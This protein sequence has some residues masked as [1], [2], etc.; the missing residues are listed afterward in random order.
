ML[1]KIPEKLR[2][3][4]E[5]ADFPLYVAGGAVRDALSGFD[6]EDIDLAAPAAA[7]EMCTL[8]ERCGFTVCGVYKNTG[9]VNLS[10]GQKKYEFTSFRTDV[11]RRG[12]NAGG[13]APAEVRFTGSIEEDAKRRDFKCNAVYYDIA[14]DRIADPL[15]GVADIRARTVN[16]T[17]DADEVFAEDGLRLMRLARQC[18]QTGF[19]PSLE[20][21]FGAKFNAARIQKI[22]PERIFAE[23]KLLL[24]ADEKHGVRF[25]H[26]DGLKLLEGT[27]VLGYILPELAAGKGMPQR[28]DFHDHDVLEHSLRAAKYA[29]PRVRLAALLHDAGKPWCYQNT[30]KYHGHDEAGA[31]IGR[32]ILERLKAPKKETETVVRL[33]GAHMYD[34]DGKARES[35]VR[36]FIAKNADIYELLLLVKQADY[37][38]CKD[39]TDVCPT[40]VK[41]EDIRK[42]M[43]D[44]GAPFT[45]KELKIDGNALKGLFP[46]EKIGKALN[47]LFFECV[48]DG[49]KN[50]P[51]KLRTAAEK[52][53]AKEI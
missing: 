43:L 16:T 23:L 39:K 37:M 50:D 44:E 6:Y 17:R 27:D 1:L 38:A 2:N 10:D 13:H 9:T 49:K 12:A 32:Q 7:D 51:E 47:T 41:W 42:K 19:T 5:K 52:L 48:Y 26:Y 8:A 14:N 40:I 45:L 46:P 28:K 18:G 36:A 11:Y 29:D 24:H 22:V 34:L 15:G 35:K 31:R 21:I 53:A 4:A 20:C 3:R 30:G 33:I 25:G